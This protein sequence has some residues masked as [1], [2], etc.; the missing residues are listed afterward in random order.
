MEK[1]FIYL[2]G[3]I[4]PGRSHLDKSSKIEWPSFIEANEIRIFRNT[5]SE[6]PIVGSQQPLKIKTDRSDRE[7]IGYLQSSQQKIM[8]QIHNAFRKNK[9]P[10]MIHA[11]SDKKVSEKG[12]IMLQGSNDKKQVTNEQ[13]QKLKENLKFTNRSQPSNTF[14]SHGPASLSSKKKNQNSSKQSSTVS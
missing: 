9:S 3:L 10:A 8:S 12:I 5:N 4:P 1:Q 13:I 14:K 11:G 2:G 6:Q 7:S